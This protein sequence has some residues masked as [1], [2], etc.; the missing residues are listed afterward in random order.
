MHFSITPSEAQKIRAEG[1]L[2]R[3]VSISVRHCKYTDYRYTAVVSKKQ[4]SAHERNRVKRIIREAMR[5]RKDRYPAGLYLI[6]YNGI[7]NNLNRS[8]V[9]RDLDNIMEKISVKQPY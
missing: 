8:Q 6:Y 9:I 5:N 1:N 2:E 7:C 3:A 4:G